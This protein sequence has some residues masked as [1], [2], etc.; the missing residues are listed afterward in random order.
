M[1][2]IVWIL[3]GVLIGIILT[4][5]EAAHH[6]KIVIAYWVAFICL[7]LQNAVFYSYRFSRIGLDL[8]HF[9]GQ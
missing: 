3:I 8:T 4:R 1:E 7:M 5:K 2:Y 9:L 6:K